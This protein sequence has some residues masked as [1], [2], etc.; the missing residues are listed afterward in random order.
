MP[1]GRL[2][3]PE[4]RRADT[5]LALLAPAR[6]IDVRVHVSVEAILSRRRFFPACARPSFGEA[7]L[8]DGLDALE[9]V[10]P[11]YDQP[12]WRTILVGQG[13]A[14]QSNR[15]DG[16]RVHR[17]VHPQALD[18][19]PVEHGIALTWHLLRVQ[20]GGE[21]DVLCLRSR[22]EPLQQVSQW[23]PHPGNDHGPGFDATQP[24]DPFLERMR[25]EDVF[26]GE[27]PR[28]LGLTRYGHAPGPGTET[29]RVGRGIGLAG[30]KFVEIVI[31]RDFVERVGSLRRGVGGI[32][33]VPQRWRDERDVHHRLRQDLGRGSQQACASEPGQERAPRRIDRLGRDLRG[34]DFVRSPDEHETSATRWALPG[35]RP[36][37][38]TENFVRRPRSDA[39]RGRN[40]G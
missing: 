23:E 40:G 17:L 37:H 24:V 26:K 25:S 10:L 18:V 9:A 12:Q 16:Q 32:G 7:D 19:G 14:V 38:V 33:L 2:P 35:S 20:Q 28:H 39:T 6:V 36:C 34:P 29:P 22:L 15:Q 5:P 21:L 3:V 8:D 31:A 13:L 1:T 27:S 11:G 30:A 4:G